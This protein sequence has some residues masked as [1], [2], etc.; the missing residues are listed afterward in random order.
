MQYGGQL[1]AQEKA[2]RQIT[3][4]SLVAIGGIFLLLFIALK[5]MRSALLVMAN[6][7]LALIGGVVMVFISGGTLSIA[8]LVS[9][10]TL[11]GIATRNGIMLISH[12]MHL[13]REEGVAFRAAIVQGSME[14]LSPILMTALVT[15]I[16]LLPLA[17]GKGEPG[18]EIQQPYGRRHSR[19]HSH[20]DS[21]EHDRDP[22]A[23]L[24]V[25]SRSGASGNAG[26]L[27]CPR[28]ACGGW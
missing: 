1:E 10:I 14:R 5:S 23:V 8:S 6:L 28:G 20:F 16:G 19:R 3:L 26:F 27:G 9:F 22:G 13:M 21:P 15:G 7:P 17:L 12:Y 25:R 4:F 24:E 18:K 2:S 11:F